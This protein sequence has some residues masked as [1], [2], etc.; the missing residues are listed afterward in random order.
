MTDLPRG[1]GDLE[2]FPDVVSQS[3]DS[4]FAPVIRF[5][6]VGTDG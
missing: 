2:T 6:V 5:C 4:T 3:V 1:K